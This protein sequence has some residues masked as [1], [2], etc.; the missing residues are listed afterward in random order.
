MAFLTQM[1]TSDGTGAKYSGY[2][3]C[4]QGRNIPGTNYLY[5]I[6]LVTDITRIVYG[7]GTILPLR[8]LTY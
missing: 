4:S 6:K 5:E 8:M 1:A 7:M 3:L 2:E